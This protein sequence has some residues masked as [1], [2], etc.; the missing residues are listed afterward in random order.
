MLNIWNKESQT[1]PYRRKG[2]V[3]AK[4]L[5]VRCTIYFDHYRQMRRSSGHAICQRWSLPIGDHWRLIYFLMFGQE[6]RLPVDDLAH[7]CRHSCAWVQKH[8]HRLQTA[9]DLAEQSLAKAAGIRKASDWAN[10]S[11]YAACKLTCLALS[12]A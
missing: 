7:T 5:I 3:S 9:F 4:G 12:S 10:A 8:Q 1:T 6:P 11:A 2:M